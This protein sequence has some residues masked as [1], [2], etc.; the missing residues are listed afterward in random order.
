MIG[1]EEHGEVLMKSLNDSKFEYAFDLNK[2]D[3]NKIRLWM[4]F[5]T[6]NSLIKLP[7]KADIKIVN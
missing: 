7:A 2:M 6:D 5:K 4:I 3:N 1:N